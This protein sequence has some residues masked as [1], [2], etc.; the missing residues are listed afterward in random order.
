[1]SDTLEFLFANN[2]AS[3]IDQPIL[4]SRADTT[5]FRIRNNVFKIAVHGENGNI[6][7]EK[8]KHRFAT[9]MHAIDT[10]QV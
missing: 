2:Y 6:T 1:M 10:F 9:I 4:Y 8:L 3:L 7:S 5:S